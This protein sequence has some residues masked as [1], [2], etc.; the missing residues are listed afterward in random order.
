MFKALWMVSGHRKPSV[1][2]SCYCWRIKIEEPS[3]PWLAFLKL[4]P[5]PSKALPAGS[6]TESGV[7]LLTTQK[8]TERQGWWKGESALFRI[9][10]TWGEGGP[11][12]DSL[13]HTISGQE[14]SQTE[15]GSYT[16]KQRSQLWPSSWNWSDQGHLDCL[17]F[18]PQYLFI[19]LFGCSSC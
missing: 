4:C 2:V 13:T 17:L 16:Q 19:Y 6:V 5:G 11:Q 3:S 12:A 10:V 9:P 15:G 1:R 18:F 7:R 8:P 14:L